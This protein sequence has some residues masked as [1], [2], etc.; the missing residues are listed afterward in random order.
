M[1]V[2]GEF[3]PISNRA[4]AGIVIGGDSVQRIALL[5]FVDNANWLGG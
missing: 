4:D 1:I 3:V 5:H 2:F